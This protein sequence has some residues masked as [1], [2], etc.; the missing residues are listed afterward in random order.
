[1]LRA[2]LT[3]PV[4]VENSSYVDNYVQRALRP[5]SGQVVIVCTDDG[6][7]P[8]SLDIVD[9]RGGSLA[10]K[11]ERNSDGTIELNIYH[12][13]A[14]GTTSLCYWFAYQPQHSLAPIHL[15]VEGHDVRKRKLY[16]DTWIDNADSPTDNSEIVD[17][18]CRLCSDGFVITK[19]HVRA[20]CQNVCNRSMCYNHEEADDMFVPLD[21][22]VVSTLPNFSLALSSSAV[23]NDLFKILHLNNR[24][25]LVDG[26]TML[27]VGDRVSSDLVVAELVNTPIGRRVKLFINLYRCD[28]KVATIESAFLY[29][30]DF[31][32]IGKTFEHKLDQHQ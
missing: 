7:Q 15:V 17:I 13:V 27:R 32:D 25:Q 5:R 16:V 30:D 29:R 10:L 18:N 28:R 6:Q 3:A 26:A 23:S 19:E 9:E 20:F 22:L 21:F 24:Y 2:L 31:V 1:W 8:V 11:V 4:I 14:S 12:Q